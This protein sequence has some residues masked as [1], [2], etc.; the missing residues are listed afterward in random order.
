VALCPGEVKYQVYLGLAYEELFKRTQPDRREIWF[1]KARQA[2]ERSVALNP[3]NGY[4]HGNL[5]R[6]LGLAAEAG[7]ADFFPGA[8]THYLAAIRIAPVT[9]LFY[10]NLILLYARYAKL[11]EA[12]AL[13]DSLEARDKE[14]APSLL[15][16]AASTFFQWR[17]DG[18]P[19]WDAKA[20][21]A[22]LPLALGWARRSVALAP[23]K[24]LDARDQAA[25]A[26]FALALASFEMAAGHPAESKAASAKAIAWGAKK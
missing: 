9:R 21:Q 6:L 3:Q 19:A 13:M 18:G 26:D 8:E 7:A 1:N 14:L 22:A 25:F 24:F 20:K 15:T 10:E 23:A 17:E 4:Y 16:A 12:A 2:Y 11:K 5:G